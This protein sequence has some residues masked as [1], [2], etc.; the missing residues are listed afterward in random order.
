[1]KQGRH[2]IKVLGLS[3]I[4]ALGL[5]AFMASAAQAGE[6]KVTNG[7]PE[8]TGTFTAKGIASETVSGTVAEGKLLVPG[9]PLTIK[10]TGGNA[11]GT[12]LLG[13]VVHATILFTGCFAEGAEGTCKPY[14]TKALMEENAAGPRG[15]ILASGLGEI[16]LME[17]K[18]YILV[19]SAKETPFSTIYWQ[20]LCSQPL[21]TKIF[22][23]T[24]FFAPNALT[25]LVNQTL[26]TIPQAELE[27]L[28]PNDKLFYGTQ[29]AWL[30]GG[31]TTNAALTGANVGKKWGGE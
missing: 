21:E 8:T 7:S 31:G 9:L 28:F 29:A 5:M 12:V 10:C 26:S 13:G 17:G 11:S 18:H 23:S 16:I 3:L 14:E 1:M 15:N 19:E 6:F 24:V 25:Q 20:R 2:G 22:G 4:A 27:T 30:D